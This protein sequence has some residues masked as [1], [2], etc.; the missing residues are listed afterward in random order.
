ML[1]NSDSKDQIPI[2]LQCSF[3]ELSGNIY[4]IKVILGIQYVTILFKSALFS[5]SL[6]P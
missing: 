5:T 1:V 6:A 4:F 3:I 2:I